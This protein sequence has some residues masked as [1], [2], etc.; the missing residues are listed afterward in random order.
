ML[1]MPVRKGNKWNKNPM[2]CNSSRVMAA[3]NDI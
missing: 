3:V 1:E 2:K